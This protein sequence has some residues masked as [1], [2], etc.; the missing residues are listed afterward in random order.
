L[1]GAKVNGFL[2]YFVFSH[3]WDFLIALTIAMSFCLFSDVD[4]ASTP[5][6]ILEC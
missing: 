4:E 3:N 1:V 2:D 6:I 5:T